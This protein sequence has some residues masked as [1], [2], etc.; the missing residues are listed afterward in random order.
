MHAEIKFPKRE[1]G[2]IRGRLGVEANPNLAR[3]E[4]GGMMH[5]QA[6]LSGDGCGMQ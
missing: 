2:A 1:G 5:H 3:R 6:A 4:G